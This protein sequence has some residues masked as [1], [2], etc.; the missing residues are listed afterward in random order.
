[1]G[2]EVCDVVEKFIEG[3]GRELSDPGSLLLSVEIDF[4]SVDPETRTELES[5]PVRICGNLWVVKPA[6]Q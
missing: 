6:L 1:M 5:A 3:L 4:G 2:W